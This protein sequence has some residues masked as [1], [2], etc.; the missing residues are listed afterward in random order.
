MIKV[1]SN[2][3]KIFFKSFQK[4]P[5]FTSEVSKIFSKICS[6]FF[7]ILFN[8]WK[9]LP[10]N[11]QIRYIKPVPS[12]WRPPTPISGKLEIFLRSLRFGHTYPTHVHLLT[13]Q[14]PPACPHYGNSVTVH[15]FHDRLGGN[16]ISQ[17]LTKTSFFQLM[18]TKFGNSSAPL[19]LS[20]K[21][22]I[23]PPVKSPTM[24]R[25]LGSKSKYSK[26]FV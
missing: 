22:L 1:S 9:N 6:K 13:N 25:K 7:K 21:H 17:N 14:L 3:F 26:Y 19:T 4:L 11:N 8:Y 12:P 24:A 10:E 16:Y 5:K 23:V 2:V 20:P 18:Q 15:T